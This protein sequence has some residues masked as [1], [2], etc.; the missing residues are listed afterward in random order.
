MS[1]FIFPLILLFLLLLILNIFDAP[2]HFDSLQKTLARVNIKYHIDMNPGKL[3]TCT[4]DGAIEES[5]DCRILTNEV[6][7]YFK[8]WELIKVH[9]T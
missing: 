1:I 8:G 6:I 4:V 3:L 2:T 9:K 5:Y 7:Y